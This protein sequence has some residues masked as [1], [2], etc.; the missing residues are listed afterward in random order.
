MKF[1]RLATKNAAG[2][3]L[4]HSLEIAGRRVAK[5][6]KITESLVADLVKDGI[7]EIVA[8]Q[9]DPGDLSENTAAARLAAHF[10]GPGV[11]APKAHTG[12]VNLHAR[13]SG[14]LML[15]TARIH[16]FNQVSEAITLA[17]LPAFDPVQ[18]NRML[19]T[20]KIIPFAVPERDIAAIEAIMAEKPDRPLLQ[21]NAFKSLKA[22][23]IQTVLPHTKASV[24]EKTIAVTRARLSSVGA[25]LSGDAQ[26]GH[27]VGAVSAALVSEAAQSADIILVIGASAIVDR[28]DVIPRAIEAAGGTVHHFGMPVD[29]GNLL[30]LG[31]DAFGKPVIGLPG[32]GRSPKPNGIDRVLQRLAAGVAVTGDDIKCMGVGGLL[33]DIAERP[34]PRIMAGPVRGRGKTGYRV[35]PVILAAGLSRRM[36]AENKLL[37]D[38]RD[39][40]MI[41]KVVENVLNA[42]LEPPLVVIGHDAQAVSG[43]LEGIAVRYAINPSYAQG[44]SSSLKSGL[45]ALGPDV[46]GVLVC[47]GDMPRVAADDVRA[48][49][50]AFDPAQGAEIIVPT[51]EAKRGNPV[52]FARRFFPEMLEIRGDVGARHL[53]GAYADHVREVPREHAGVLFDIDTPDML[54]KYRRR[55]V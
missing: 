1:G 42:G 15:D 43:A 24:P 9:L 50:T 40:P 2:A 46:D 54:Q 41:R 20:I 31:Q 51:F 11:S 49:V 14:I 26:T 10:T 18:P 6:S 17:T 27:H 7:T 22:H 28:G 3:L 48:I 35:A 12:R 23:L 16:R 45:A 8:A 32:C 55:E 19:A 39:G 21:V 52:L 25:E 34:A 4:G 37:A 36:G 47:L 44:L 5:G 29:P 53:I 30:L 13:I 38:V 33:T